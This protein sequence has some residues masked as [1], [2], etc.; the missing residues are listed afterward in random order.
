MVPVPV[1]D[2]SSSDFSA[3]VAAAAAAAAEEKIVAIDYAALYQHEKR[4]ARLWMKSKQQQQRNDGTL[5]SGELLGDDQKVDSAQSRTFPPWTFRAEQSSATCT[6]AG[7]CTRNRPFATLQPLRN[8]LTNDAVYTKGPS[9][10]YYQQHY[11]TDQSWQNALTQ[12]LDQL[13]VIHPN[14]HTDD[15]RKS[16]GAWT[17]LP[18]AQRK[19]SLWD[20]RWLAAEKTAA[21][22]TKCQQITNQSPS[23]LDS[24]NDEDNDACWFPEPLQHLVDAVAADLAQLGCQDVDDENDDDRLLRFAAANKFPPPNH[25]LINHYPHETHG[26]LPHTDGPAYAP[27][28][29]T[30]SLGTGDVLLNFDKIGIMNANDDCSNSND[31]KDNYDESLPAQVLL[32]GGGSLVVFANDAYTAFRHSI[33]ELN[34]TIE[35]DN[36]T[37]TTKSRN[38][39]DCVSLPTATTTD[40]HKNMTTAAIV[41]GSNNDDYHTECLWTEVASTQCLNAETGTAVVRSSNRISITIRHKY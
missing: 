8:Y 13:P 22:A 37:N 28:T 14:N 39:G 4:L 34:D 11:L 35:W 2:A 36:S 9:T 6:S 17:L 32:H 15:A 16:N 41:N 26:I 23:S 24:A 12:W 25:I 7:A 20:G 21:A 18:H 29:A 38:N 10:I 1:P 3:I 27:Y 19:V 31:K 5:T 30:I 40:P 33:A